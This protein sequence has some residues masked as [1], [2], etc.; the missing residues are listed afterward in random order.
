MSMKYQQLLSKM[1]VHDSPEFIDWIRIN[2]PVVYE[3]EH[4]I[5]I[6]NFKYHFLSRPWLVAFAKTDKLEM[7]DLLRVYGDWG[8]LK[9][10]PKDM[11]I[12]RVHFHIYRDSNLVLSLIFPLYCRLRYF[13]K[14]T[15]FSK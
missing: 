2:N 11:T 3:N 6:E 9:N 12:N 1:P 15:L 4:W 5:V 7:T 13:F 8:L 14:L 10:L